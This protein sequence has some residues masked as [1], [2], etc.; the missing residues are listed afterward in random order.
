MRANK[1]HK[2]KAD[3]IV[4][5]VVFV[6]FA[7]YAISLLFPFLWCLMNSFKTR[8]DFFLNINGLPEVW[9]VENWVNSFSLSADRVSLPMMYFNSIFMTVGA[10]FLSLMSCSATAYIVTKYEF[11][12]RDAL[13]SIAVII[14]MIPTMGSMA[15]TY[16]LYTSI[17]LVNTYTGYFIF[18]CGGFGSYFLIM[19]GFYKNLSWTYA[20]AAQIDGA[21]HFRIYFTIMIPMALP[22]FVSIG[23]LAAI[24]YW[25][26]YFTVYM[27]MPEKATIAY[28]I[29]RIADQN[30]SNLPQVF[31]AMLFSMI[32]VLIV[33]SFFQKTIMNN[34][35]VGGIKG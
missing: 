18:A 31:A 5:W 23:I 21:G 1:I 19:Y 17:G 35:T 30:K 16:K 34:M 29:Q 10:T 26:D 15:S 9:T 11:P 22:V 13:Y 32:P 24:G 33:F 28:G 2:T 25:N 27:Y 14:M 20:E 6:I 4:M 7:L 3:T 8:R 12:G